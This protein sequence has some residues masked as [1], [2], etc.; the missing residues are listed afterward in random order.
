M[1]TRRLPTLL[2]L[3]CLAAPLPAGLWP[4]SLQAQEIDEAEVKRLALEAIRENPGIVMEAVEM[5]RRQE[6]D[7]QAQAAQTALSDRREAIERDPNAPVLGNPEGDVTMVE[8]F[9]YNCPYCRRAAPDVHALIAQDPELRVV[10]RE[11]PI[12]GE[13]S[14]V[15]ARASLAAE[16]QD[17]YE[18]FHFALMEI[19]GRVDD[20][21]IEAAAEAAGLDMDRLR[22]D[23][24]APEVDAHIAA[25]MELAQALGITGT[26]AFVIGDQVVPG[27]V[28]GEELAALVEEARAAE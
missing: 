24:E 6:A 21:A 19:S 2:A 4:A 14:V 11:W 9:D 15:A 3:A 10:F 7:A 1:A 5:L 20:A 8:F 16:M 13:D 26:P 25:S 17:G 22:A 18:A 23:M 28:P 12:L 27:A